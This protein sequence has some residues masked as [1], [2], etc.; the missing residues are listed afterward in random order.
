[1]TS[2]MT[3]NSALERVKSVS[4]AVWVVGTGVIL[5]VILLARRSSG[6]VSAPTVQPAGGGGGEAG[7]GQVVAE[8]NALFGALYTANQANRS[9]IDRITA[10]LTQYRK[11]E[12]IQQRVEML[13]SRKSTY[14]Q[15][16]TTNL[17]GLNTLRDR[18]SKTTDPAQRKL[19]QDRIAATQTRITRLT[20]QIR[21][22][23][24]NLS[25]AQS[26]EKT[27]IGTLA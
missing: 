17:V 25:A 12:G 11:L 20:A 8:V 3:I 13:L 2:S 14:Q 16:L 10:Q 1:M 22:T 26:Q 19:L 15:A 6:G 7:P 24:T 23:S 21:S 27:V 4:P 9:I 18:L 5:A